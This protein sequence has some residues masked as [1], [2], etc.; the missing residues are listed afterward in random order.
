LRICNLIYLVI[1]VRTVSYLEAMHEKAYLYHEFFKKRFFVLRRLGKKILPIDRSFQA[2]TFETGPDRGSQRERCHNRV[3]PRHP[4]KKLPSDFYNLICKK[5]YFFKL[6]NNFY[7]ENFIVHYW[8]I[9]WYASK[10]RKMRRKA[11]LKK[12]HSRSTCFF[13]GKMLISGGKT[14]RRAQHSRKDARETRVVFFKPFSLTYFYSLS[15]RKKIL[16]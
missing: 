6:D 10:S 8:N 5:I 14:A 3:L 15:D 1:V 13:N 2:K 16:K 11:K 9:F 7:D 4:R 12:Y